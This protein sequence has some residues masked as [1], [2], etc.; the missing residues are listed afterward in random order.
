MEVHRTPRIIGGEGPGGV[1]GCREGT[2][3]IATEWSRDQNRP[4]EG[5]SF[6]RQLK[7]WREPLRTST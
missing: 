6:T 3:S 7:S 2:R 4:Q 5:R 1:Y